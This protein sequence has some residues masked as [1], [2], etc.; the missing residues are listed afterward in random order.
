[1]L[2]IGWAWIQMH[3]N[4][5]SNDFYV[6]PHHQQKC[7]KI[8]KVQKNYKNVKDPW[9][10]ITRV[11]VVVVLSASVQGKGEPGPTLVPSASWVMI[12]CHLSSLS[13]HTLHFF[14]FIDED[15]KCNKCW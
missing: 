14:M 13:L 10:T 2:N 7:M 9:E 4:D 15:A 3:K 12:W 5:G 8:M 11:V 6:I 1:M